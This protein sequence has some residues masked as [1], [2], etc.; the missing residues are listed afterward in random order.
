M[1]LEDAGKLLG[2]T[3]GKKTFTFTSEFSSCVS[4]AGVTLRGK[5][6][7]LKGKG[8]NVKLKR[9]VRNPLVRA[10]WGTEAAPGQVRIPTSP[11]RPSSL[12]ASHLDTYQLC[13]M[14]EI[15]SSW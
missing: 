11:E 8:N 12:K 4:S 14:C 10:G 15:L 13:P 9:T 7:F 3:W 6:H 5:Y 2:V 1:E